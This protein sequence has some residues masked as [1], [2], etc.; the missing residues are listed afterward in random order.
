MPYCTRTPKR[1]EASDNCPLYCRI[2]V[3]PKV[4]LNL[5]KSYDTSFIWFRDMLGTFVARLI[6]VSAA[7]YRAQEPLTSKGTCFRKTI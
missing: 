3:L 2:Y 6:F 7:T 5:P 1:T 4:T